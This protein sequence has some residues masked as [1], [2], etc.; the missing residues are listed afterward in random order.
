MKLRE[1]PFTVNKASFKLSW[2][3]FR[4]DVNRVTK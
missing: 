1:K 3:S 4:L 2:V